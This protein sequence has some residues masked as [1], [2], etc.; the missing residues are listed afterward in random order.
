MAKGKGRGKGKRRTRRK[1]AFNVVNAAESLVLANAGSM[2]LFGT[3]LPAFAQEGW[4]LP[5]SSGPLGSGHS[6]KFSAA[7]L[8]KGI[9][10]GGESFGMSGTHFG[11]PANSYAAVWAS[12]KS[13]MRANGPMALG[14]ILLVPIGF[15]VGKRLLS[16]PRNA[17]NR[18]LDYA[19][20][21]KEVRV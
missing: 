7:E 16:K 12:M 18:F 20:V 21:G 8:I 13:N 6:T 9:I 2:A 14:T 11:E 15:R 1:R 19:G 10:P 4:A 17:T 3:S 5:S